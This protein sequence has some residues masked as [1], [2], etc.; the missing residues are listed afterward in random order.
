VKFS[1]QLSRMLRL[2]VLERST[3]DHWLTRLVVVATPLSTS[4]IQV[5]TNKLSDHRDD[6]SERATGYW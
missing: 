2:G 1:P 4:M 5:T 3:L 6:D